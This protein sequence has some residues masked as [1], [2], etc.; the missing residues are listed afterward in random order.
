MNF[1]INKPDSISFKT[2][3]T[4]TI[5]IWWD[6]Q[7]KNNGW[8]YKD[9]TPYIYVHT[10]YPKIIISLTFYDIHS[11]MIGVDGGYRKGCIFKLKDS[12]KFIDYLN[13]YIKELK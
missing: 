9:G 2:I 13:D 5:C 12:Q 8:I 1:N 10:D 3:D 11:T 6:T 4:S 7:L